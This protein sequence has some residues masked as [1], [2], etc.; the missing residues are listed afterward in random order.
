[1]TLRVIGVDRHAA[2]SST[3]R[4]FLFGAE[5]KGVVLFARDV[6]RGKLTGTGRLAIVRPGPLIRNRTGPKCSRTGQLRIAEYA[7]LLWPL[8]SF[9][10]PFTITLLPDPTE[11]MLLF[12]SVTR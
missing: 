12:S 8:E 4:R 2:L 1:M 11:T 5:A 6:S 3:A 9:A 7:R 10:A